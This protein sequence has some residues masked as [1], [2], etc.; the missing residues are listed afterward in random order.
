MTILE[1]LQKKY[2]VGVPSRKC[3]LILTNVI[4]SNMLLRTNAIH[5][6]MRKSTE[7]RLKYRQTV[8]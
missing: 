1:Y 2:G 4:S 7:G 5:S 6:R 8:S 3:Q